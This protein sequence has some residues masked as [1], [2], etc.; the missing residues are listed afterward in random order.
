[1]KTS[2]SSEA[3]HE[4]G[5]LEASPR[6]PHGSDEGPAVLVGVVALHSPQTLFSVVASCRNGQAMWS[7][8]DI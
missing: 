1:M 3:Y 4:H 8:P 2:G 7:N 6:S 5:H